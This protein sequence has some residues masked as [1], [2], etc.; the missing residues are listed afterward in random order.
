MV[1]AGASPTN[2]SIETESLA[3]RAGKVPSKIVA[4]DRCFAHF[5]EYKF[6]AIVPEYSPSEGQTERHLINQSFQGTCRL[7]LAE[8]IAVRP[9]PKVAMTVSAI[10]PLDAKAKRGARDSVAIESDF[11]IEDSVGVRRT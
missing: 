5:S 3:R 2:G 10:V 7:P 4:I 1:R 11:S 6:L 8:E 9:S